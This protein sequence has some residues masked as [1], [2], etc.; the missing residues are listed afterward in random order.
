MNTRG[1]AHRPVGEASIWHRFVANRQ[2]RAMHCI[3][4]LHRGL[5]KPSRIQMPRHDSEKCLTA[6][7]LRDARPR[8]IGAARRL[9]TVVT[10]RL[11][12]VIGDPTR[13]SSSC[14]WYQDHLSLSRHAAAPH[15][16]DGTTC[17]SCNRLCVFT[18]AGK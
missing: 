6:S 15:S 1:A 9:H 14:S 5:I 7:V 18:T 12:C 13:S 2:T 16:G 17:R 3:L 4:D 10:K 11:G 8:R